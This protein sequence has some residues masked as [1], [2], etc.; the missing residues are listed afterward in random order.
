MGTRVV[1]GDVRMGFIIFACYWVT[2]YNGIPSGG[3]M[4][5]SPPSNPFVTP[6]EV[7]GTL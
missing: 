7:E 3:Q 2:E 1:M 4:N 5:Y 6:I